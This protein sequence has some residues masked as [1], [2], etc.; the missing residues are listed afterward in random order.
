MVPIWRPGV[1]Y[2]GLLYGPGDD[3]WHRLSIFGS[4][5]KEIS[6][7]DDLGVHGI[8]FHHD[9]PMVLLGILTGVLIDGHIGIYWESGTLWAYER[10]RRTISWKPAYP[11]A[12]VFVLSG[13][14]GR[15]KEEISS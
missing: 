7:I 6:T 4:R 10:A 3:T 2:C 1:H 11:G 14:E 15:V 9:L 12:V 5:T 13:Q 8:I